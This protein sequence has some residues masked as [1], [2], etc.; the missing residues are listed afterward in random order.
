MFFALYDLKQKITFRLN[1]ESWQLIDIWALFSCELN[2][3]NENINRLLFEDQNDVSR[4][5]YCFILG[6]Y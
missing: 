3:Y 5:P 1:L 2:E 6:E 4:I